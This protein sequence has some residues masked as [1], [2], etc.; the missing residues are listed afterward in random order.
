MIKTHLH[1]IEKSINMEEFSQVFTPEIKK[2]IG[3]VRKYGFD[4]RAVGGVVRDFIIGKTP[5]DVDFA[6]DADP[7]EL[8]FIFDLEGVEYDPSGI[9]HGT[10]KAVFGSEKIDVTSISYRLSL[11]SGKIKIDKPRSWKD[12]SAMR[13]LTINSMSVDMNGILYDYQGGLEDLKNSFVRFCPNPQKKI[14]NDPYTILRWFKALALFDN[15][16]WLRSDRELVSKNASLVKLVK[17]ESRTRKLL[18]S[19]Q[20]SQ[21]WSKISSLMCSTGVAK[22]LDL[23]C[24][25]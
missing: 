25:Q 2:V 12:E 20:A 5:R 21:N 6:T 17:E 10:V 7:A 19:L 4:I 22:E 14:I 15:P 8:I 23:T 3:I 24:S 18:E 16:R 9:G 11:K 1:E 13:D